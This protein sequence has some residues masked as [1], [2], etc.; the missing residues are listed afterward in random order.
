M[1]KALDRLS[2]TKWRR[3]QTV[4]CVEMRKLLCVALLDIFVYR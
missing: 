3:V 1:A 4:E 2:G